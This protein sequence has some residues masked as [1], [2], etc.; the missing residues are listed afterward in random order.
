MD[1]AGLVYRAEGL[2][3]L[4]DQL[5]ASTVEQG[6]AAAGGQVEF[7]VTDAANKTARWYDT[8][9]ARPSSEFIY[10]I[11]GFGTQMVVLYPPIPYPPVP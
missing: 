7:Y 5:H 10:A 9:N 4:A 3:S 2:G 6:A 1:V 8:A 11:E